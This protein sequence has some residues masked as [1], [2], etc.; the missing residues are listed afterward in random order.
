MSEPVKFC[1][2]CGRSRSCLNHLNA[3]LPPRAAEKWLRR[4]CTTEGQPCDIKYQAGISPALESM[5][6]R[7]R[8][9]RQR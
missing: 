4:T 2:A 5:L 8:E 9:A 6:A 3:D 7:Y 1:V